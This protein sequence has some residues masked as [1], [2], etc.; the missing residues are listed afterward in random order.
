[1]ELPKCAILIWM[2]Y[3]SIDTMLYKQHRHK[4]HSS[5]SGREKRIPTGDRWNQVLCN[6]STQSYPTYQTTV[7]IATSTLKRSNQSEPYHSWYNPKWCVPMVVDY[8]QCTINSISLDCIVESSLCGTLILVH[9]FGRIVV[10]TYHYFLTERYFQLPA[11]R[12]SEAY[13]VAYVI[14]RPLS[15]RPVRMIESF[16]QK[17][18]SCQS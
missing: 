13:V 4:I 16:T 1:M 18:R 6:M 9:G 2:S 7:S 3:P 17:I 12:G 15:F 8:S 10:T 11:R 14:K 5:L